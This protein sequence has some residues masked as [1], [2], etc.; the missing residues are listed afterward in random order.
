[1]LTH[2]RI[3]NLALVTDLSLELRSG[4]NAITGETGA[5]KSIIMGALNLILGQRADRNQIRSGADQCVVE[6]VFETNDLHQDFEMML[7]DLGLEPCEEGLLMLKRIIR[8]AGANRQFVNGS[9]T[10]LDALQSIGHH[11]VDMHGPHDHQSL[12]DGG[13]QL[14]ILDAYGNLQSLRRA[15]SDCMGSLRALEQHKAS[16][17]IDEQTYV[18]RL[19]LLRYQVREIEGAQ[20][21]LTAAEALELDY[22]RL[23]NAAKL[24]EM[25]QGAL[26]ALNAQEGSLWDLTGNIGR[27]IDSLT[28]L[29]PRGAEIGAMHQQMVYHISELEQA[30]SHYVDG[31]EL[32]PAMLH[33]MD[34]RLSALQSLKRKYGPTLEQVLEFGREAS[35]NLQDLETLESTLAQLN[36]DID[37]QNVALETAGRRL[38]KARSKVIPSLNQAVRKELN[39]LGFLKGRFD[40]QLKSSELCTKDGHTVCHSTGLDQVDFLFGPNAGEPMQSLKLIASSGEMARVMLAL[41][42][43][44]AEQDQVPVLVFDEVD[45]NVGG[46]TGN[47]VGQKMQEIGHCRQV[48]CITHLAPVAAAASF[49]FLVTKKQQGQRTVS[50]IMAL[51]F[52]GRVTEIARMLG[53]GGPEALSHAKAMLKG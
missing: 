17:V 21:D 36:A 4:F 48:I 26:H 24:L 1:M 45:A 33:E 9:P 15:F 35:S 2:L 3:K 19:E 10:S 44:L 11:L 25:A 6:A 7:D 43:V 38:S 40:I 30:L 16:L 28:S 14:D 34:E 47:V 5:G 42:T 29:D 32:D 37:Q 22:D 41:K 49:H 13:R 50:E 52:D 53:S 27:F 51:D 23:M 8:T 20:I 12:L 18:Q 31:L 39:N 46:E